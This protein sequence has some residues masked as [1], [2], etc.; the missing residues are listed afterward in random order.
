MQEINM[1]ARPTLKSIAKACIAAGLPA[2]IELVKGNGYF[3]F[4]CEEAPNW[5][6]SSVY[7]NFLNDLTLDQWV[8][9]AKTLSSRHH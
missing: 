9:E 8:E 6:S 4:W 1:T 2:D 5:H 7:T 3:Y